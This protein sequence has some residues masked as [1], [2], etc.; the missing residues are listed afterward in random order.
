MLAPVNPTQ[1]TLPQGIAANLWPAP[2]GTPGVVIVHGHGSRKE[3]HVDFAEHVSRRN[4]AALALDLRGHGESAGELDE[5][6]LDDVLS[7]VDTLAQR[8]HAPV[9]L[10][11]SS[12]G[13]FLAL[14]AGARSAL[15]K[16]VV[17][18][19]PAQGPMLARR[20][21]S[22]WPRTLDT[23]AAVRAPGVARAYWHA[24]DDDTVPWGGTRRLAELSPQPMRLRIA[25][26]GGHRTLQH[27]PQVLDESAD[28][29]AEHLDA[30][31]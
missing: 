24:I 10:R 20:L 16:A 3:N 13:G 8:G 6:C 25:M 15:V 27:D 17:A 23:H 14:H 19:C 28:F 9:G 31:N 7:A 22:D 1:M 26:R 4:M 12:L 5:H 29:L 2:A 11:G 18:I 21:K 30:G